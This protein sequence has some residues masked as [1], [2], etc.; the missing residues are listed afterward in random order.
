M[1]AIAVL[2]LAAGIVAAAPRP[3]AAQTA[4]FYFSGDGRLELA[5]A[6][7]DERLNVR[8]RDADGRYDP[9]AIAA[10]E[11]FF[12]SRSDG[13][14]G[15]VSLRLIELIAFAGR[16]ARAGRLTLVSGYRSPELNAALRGDGR[17]VAQA[18]LHTEGLAADVAFA[19]VDLGRLWR[20]LRDLRVGGVGLYRAD[21]FL[22]LDTGQPRFWEPATSA[23]DRNLSA[24]NA[25]LFARTDFDRYAGL[26]G[27]VVSL[28]SLTALPVAVH[29][30]AMLGEAAV[31]LVPLDAGTE[32][33]GECWRFEDEAEAYR[34][35]VTS[36]VSPPAE[37]A[38][39]RLRLCATGGSDR[40]R[41]ILSNPVER[42]APARR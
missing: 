21:G 42:L 13:A 5:H 38:P 22:H 12:R 35:A 27:A 31:D 41:E 16:R 2:L 8:Y 15:R 30:R 17:R 33:A 9:E 7:F 25:R 29:R 4:R 19:G 14:Q 18:S 24:D 28:H 20:D 39:L 23:V 1:R 36:A 10:I 34:L 40:D 32:L 11:R 6:H 26:E 3:A 37:R